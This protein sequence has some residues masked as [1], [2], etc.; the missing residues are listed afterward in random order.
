MPTN[1]VPADLVEAAKR[2]EIAGA[3]F[4]RNSIPG[5]ADAWSEA[6]AAEGRNSPDEDVDAMKRVT[7]E[8]VNRVAKQYLVD[9]N[10]I[11]AELKPVPSGAA[12]ASKGFGGT[13]QLTS[14]PTKPVELPAWASSELLSL[15]IP[16]GPPPVADMTLPNGMR[17]IVRTVKITPTVSVFGS[18]QHDARMETPPGKDGVADVLRGSVFVWHEEPRPAGI[19]EGPRRYRGRRIGRFRFLASGLEREFL[20][21]SSIA[22]RQRI[23]SRAS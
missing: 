20:T 17:L 1:G 4:R 7:P 19:S 21:R 6:L 9:Q 5:L 15:E 10:S 12:V 11:T 16:A 3:E 14:A 13:E 2:R 8:D 18:V 22:G 23:E